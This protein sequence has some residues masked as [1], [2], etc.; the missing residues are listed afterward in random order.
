VTESYAVHAERTADGRRLVLMGSGDPAAQA[1]GAARLH[2]VTPSWRDTDPPGAIEMDL[3]WPAVVQLANEYGAAWRPGPHLV[4]W[5][6]GEVAR[7]TQPLPPTLSFDVPDGLEPMPHQISGAHMLALT[8]GGRGVLWDDRRTGK[9]ITA[10]LALRE[11]KTTWAPYLATPQQSIIVIAPAAAVLDWC[12]AFALWW[13]EVACTPWLGTPE[14]RRRRMGGAGVYVVSWGT[15]K[16]DAQDRT[17]LRS[18]LMHLG[19]VALV[20]DE[21]HRAKNPTADRTRAMERLAR[22]ASIFM[23]LTGSPIAHTIKD[24]QPSIQF[25]HPGNGGSGGG[26]LPSK[27]RMIDRWAWTIDDAAYGEPEVMGLSPRGREEF[28]TCMLGQWRWTNRVDVLDEPPKVHTVREVELPAEWRRVYDEV[29][30]QML[31]ELPDDGGELPS[32][33]TLAQLQQLLQLANSACDVEVTVSWDEETGEERKHYHMLPKLPSWKIDDLLHWLDGRRGA[34]SLV[35]APSRKLIELAG[36]QIERE[37]GLRIGYMIGGQGYR[38]RQDTKAR[39]QAGQ[40]DVMCCTTGAGSEAVTL[41][42]ADGLYYLQRPW[43]GIES[44]QS[45]DRASGIGAFERE[46]TDVSDAVAR[47]TVD[48]RVRDVLTAKAGQFAELVRDPRVVAAVLGG[49]S[50]TKIKPRRTG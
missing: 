30:D 44:A 25:L 42:R 23:A 10:I 24:L 2:A 17:R 19:H 14:R 45:E 16:T 31:A 21:A 20:V 9:T 41:H 12:E 6:G 1:R 43:S 38:R 3:T 8:G 18:P 7:R 49:T 48:S 33:G 36:P 39:F 4:E 47:N 27:D 34:H 13:P 22:P 40:L 37:L 28:H 5:I 29:E 11:I 32:F 50:V 15:I 35:F 46:Q 26:W